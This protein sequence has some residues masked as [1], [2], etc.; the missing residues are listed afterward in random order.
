LSW[1]TEWKAISDRISGLL[2]AGSFY[3]QDSDPRDAHSIA[4]NELLPHAKSIFQCV[5][6]FRQTYEKSLPPSALLCL[7]RIT[8]DGPNYL[9]SRNVTGRKGI[10]A[11]LT[12]LASLNTELTYALSDIQAIAR[13]ISERAFIHLQRTL[14]VDAEIREKWLRAYEDKPRAERSCERFGAVHLLA[15]GIWAFKV[16]AEGGR[17]DLVLGEPLIDSQQIESSAEALV[18]TEW[19]VVRKLDEL[20]GK[21][22]QA[23]SQA[24]SYSEGVLAG[25]ELASYRYLVIVSESQLSMPADKIKNDINYRYV[26]IAVDPKIPSKA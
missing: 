18:L 21:L 26:N 1:R 9:V 8:G 15:H 23:F 6:E 19:K 13:R 2:E 7:K 10:Q 14:M 16:D 25:F 20:R 5:S 12:S 22:R 11:I 3:F 17:T 4:E 24:E